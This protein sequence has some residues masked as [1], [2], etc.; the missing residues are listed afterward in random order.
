MELRKIETKEDFHMAMGAV[1]SSVELLDIFD[2]D[3]WLQIE[4]MASGAG[5]IL[6]PEL[7]QAM[8]K[9]PQWDIKVAVMRAASTYIKTIR[10]IRAPLETPDEG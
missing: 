4:A 8:Q 3:N 9:D 5:A 10:D 7:L 6:N 2:W 1:R